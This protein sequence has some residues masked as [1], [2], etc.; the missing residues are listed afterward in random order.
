VACVDPAW[1][2][3][4]APLGG[5]VMAT[6]LRAMT[7]ELAAA[8]L[9]PR[10]VTA[11]FPRPLIHDLVEIQVETLRR[12][13]RLATVQAHALQQGGLRC[14]VLAAFGR[15]FPAVA[16]WEAEPPAAPPPQNPP[17]LT[18]PPGQLHHTVSTYGFVRC[19]DRR[20]CW[21]ATRPWPAP[22]PRGA[23]DSRAR[24]ASEEEL[25]RDFPDY[26]LGALPPLGAL[27]HA[28]VCV[29]PEVLGHDSVTFAAGSQTESVKMGIQE[30]F[31]TG[32]FTTVSLV[33]QPERG[34]DDR[35]WSAAGSPAGRGRWR[36]ASVVMVPPAPAAGGCSDVRGRSVRPKPGP[37]RRPAGERM[38]D[39]WL[40]LTTMP[41]RF[42]ATGPALSSG[43]QPAQNQLQS[44]DAGSPWP[45]SWRVGRGI[46][47]QRW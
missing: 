13:R 25:G 22:G 27:L 20:R 30:L 14:T 34:S 37:P 26:E 29:D 18:S 8:D 36:A 44:A 6:I 5:A 1:D 42:P 45:P 9:A 28:Q 7:A 21:A 41:S 38:R 17:K 33:K 39:P 16:T 19:S 15:P 24:L 35:V 40:A 32:G 3:P 31:R 43:S 47:R 46:P 23:G 2:G 11:H 12:G 10:S 4:G